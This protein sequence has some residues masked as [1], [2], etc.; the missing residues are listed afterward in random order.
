MR[1]R[2]EDGLQLSSGKRLHA[3][4]LL[5][6]REQC[7]RQQNSLTGRVRRGGESWRSQQSLR[8]D[9]FVAAANTFLKLSLDRFLGGLDHKVLLLQSLLLGLELDLG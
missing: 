3:R 2:H 9:N 8:G 4:L 1:E 7:K 6:R 5:E